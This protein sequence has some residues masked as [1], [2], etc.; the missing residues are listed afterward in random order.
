[1]TWNIFDGLLTRGKVIQARALHEK[2]K[3]DLADQ[4]RQIE[5]QVRTAYSDFIEAKEVLDSQQTVLAEADEA[6]REARARAEAGTG[7]QLDV[8][9]AETSL[10]QARTTN[11]QA[12]HDYAAARAK[13]ERAIGEDMSKPRR[14]NNPVSEGRAPRGPNSVTILRL[15]SFAPWLNFGSLGTTT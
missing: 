7:T 4:S 2:S 11:V 9:D 15:Q 1:M 6:L 3:T 13:L 8:L 14:R 5:L 12:L 10:T